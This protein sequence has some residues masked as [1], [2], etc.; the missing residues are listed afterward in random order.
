AQASLSR[1][2]VGEA[3]QILTRHLQ[4]HPKDTSARSLL[5]EAYAMAGEN[6]RALEQYQEVVRLAPNNS[7]ALAALGQMYDRAGDPDQAEPILARAAKLS[8]AAPQIRTEWATVLARLHRYKEAASALE[9]VLPPRAPEERIAF[10]RLK[11]SVAAGLGNPAAAS[12]EMEKAL[13][14]SP[15][16][17]GL[18]VATAAAQAQARNWRRAAGLAAPL[19]AGTRDP[20]A[21]LVLLEAQ[22][23]LQ[24][25]IG[26]TLESL[27]T[28][29]M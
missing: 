5:A 22:L 8:G 14:L 3:I 18:R 13:A 11:A 2:S 23:G 15:E 28:V 27:R 9:S 24:Q 6:N 29:N 10:Y 1:G 21:G 16:D 12:S 26:Q 25:D 17:A 19:F 20:R 7:A 4:E